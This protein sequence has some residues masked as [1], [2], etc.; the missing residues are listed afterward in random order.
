MA[1]VVALATALLVALGCDGDAGNGADGTGALVAD[2]AD[3]ALRARAAELL[4]EVERLSGLP[5]REALRLGVRSRAEL[6]EFLEA[7]LEEQFADERVESLVRVYA[8]LGLV[9]DTLDLEPLLSRLLKEQVAGFYDPA[10][11]TLF[12][13]EGISGDL[14]DGV[15]VHEMVHAL[16][17]QY[18]DLDSLVE[19]TRERND[20]GMAV[21]AAVEG[22][23]TYVMYEWMLSRMAG[24]DVDLSRMPRLSE[25]FDSEALGAAGVEM[26]ELAQA[27]PV[28]R[29]QLLFPYVNGLDFIQ[30]RWGGP[31][32]R[33]PPLGEGL[34]RTTE[35]VLHPARWGAPE[36]EA[37]SPLEFAAD[38]PAG[39]TDV[40]SDGMGE[41]DI[42]IFLR[43]FLDDRDRADAAARG[44][45]GDVYRLLEG[46]PGE[47]L[48]WV[49]RWDAESEAGEFA[50]AAERAFARRY[51]EGAG[52]RV[53]V[54]RTGE[55]MVRIVDAPT[56]ASVPSAE[57]AAVEEA[58]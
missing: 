22:H 7:E 30:V 31:E 11:D 1:R 13:V 9:P 58:R 21:Q 56:G 26:P 6:E 47:V 34:P 29:E 4:P 48:V 20:P 5:A 46:P 51:A 17:D 10:S 18:V 35:Q 2:G 16:Q 23:A 3:D 53:T 24:R 25:S 50:R 14:V 36:I 44:W 32:G 55:R 37:P 54:E 43:E 40:Y 45:D 42:R 49:S 52:R 41:A 12:V 28:I 57:L 8:R 19:A 39:W 15:L 33:V 38:P 27:P